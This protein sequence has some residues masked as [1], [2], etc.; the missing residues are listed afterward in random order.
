MYINPDEPIEIRRNKAT[1]R[2][3]AYNAR[4]DG[5]TVR[6]D[7]IQIDDTT[8]YIPDLD[9]IPDAY[10]PSMNR[11]TSTKVSEG[12]VGGAGPTHNSHPL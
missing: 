11:V 5:K 7:W 3:L 2:K 12:V 6:N 9:K 4:Q 1:F 10:K 8:Y